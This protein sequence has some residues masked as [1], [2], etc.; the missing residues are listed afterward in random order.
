MMVQPIRIGLS[1][2]CILLVDLIIVILTLTYS[3]LDY[4]LE[5]ILVILNSMVYFYILCG[6]L[7]CSC[8]FSLM[9]RPSMGRSDT[10]FTPSCPPPFWKS[11]W[12]VET[13]GSIARRK[14][15]ASFGGGNWTRV[16]LPARNRNPVSSD[17]T[18]RK[19][20]IS[21]IRNSG[22]GSFEEG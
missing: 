12:W 15:G 17:L 10:R 9:R 14:S 4:N 16:F 7:M 22:V 18:I 3:S 2:T 21:H 1:V 19:Y 20:I 8:S 13:L 5:I 11:S 6:L